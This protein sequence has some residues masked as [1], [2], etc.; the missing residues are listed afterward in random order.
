MDLF[1]AC[2]QLNCMLTCDLVVHVAVV[3][4]SAHFLRPDFNSGCKVAEACSS[5]RSKAPET[6]GV[7][8]GSRALNHSSA[9]G[10]SKSLD[11]VNKPLLVCVG[12]GSKAP[13]TVMESDTI[14]P[15]AGCRRTTCGPHSPP[16]DR[17]Q[18]TGRG[19][20]EVILSVSN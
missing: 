13:P 3:S 11:S 2:L 5:Y 18:T 19:T 15:T 12:V 17:R 14:T 7:S 4:Q 20:P 10:S 9:T 16:S 6:G 8:A 1:L